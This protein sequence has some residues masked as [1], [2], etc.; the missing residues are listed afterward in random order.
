MTVNIHGREY[1]MVNERITEFKKDHEGGSIRTKILNLT[2]SFVVMKASV[3]IGDKLMATGHAQEDRDGVNKINKTSYVENCETS[4][5]GRALGI[6]G[7]G[8]DTAIASA[9]EVKTAI[10]KQENNNPVEKATPP[11][12]GLIK[13]LMAEKKIPTAIVTVKYSVKELSE[14]DKKQ[15]DDAIKYIKDY[16]G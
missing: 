6:L 1:T 7:Y 16:R 9:E 8:I 2:E 4:A 12:L 15:A 11:Q 10:E 14:L 5:I 13:K 3:F